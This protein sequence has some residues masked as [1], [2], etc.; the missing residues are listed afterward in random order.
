M[1]AESSA[2]KAVGVKP[3]DPPPDPN[4][5]DNFDVIVENVLRFLGV[6]S[7]VAF[8]ATSKS[9]RI[10]MTGEVEYRK[11]VISDTEIE[12]ARLMSAQ[13]QSSTLSSYIHKKLQ[14]YFDVFPF[15][16]DTEDQTEPY[17]LWDCGLSEEMFNKIKELYSHVMEE[18]VEGGQV[19]LNYLRC[20]D[21]LAAKKLVYDG[22]RLIDDEIGVFYTTKLTIQFAEGLFCDHFYFDVQEEDKPFEDY[23]VYGDNDDNNEEDS[24]L[25]HFGDDAPGDRIHLFHEERQ[26]FFSIMSD[27]TP[28]SLF[29]LPKCFFEFSEIV[30]SVMSIPIECIKTA[31]RPAGRLGVNLSLLGQGELEPGQLKHVLI[32]I[33]RE[34]ENIDAFRVVA[35]EMFYFQQGKILFYG[36]G[37]TPHLAKVIRF[38]GSAVFLDDSGEANYSF[39]ITL[40]FHCL[41]SIRTHKTTMMKMTSAFTR[42]ICQKI[43]VHNKIRMKSTMMTTGATTTTTTTIKMMT[44]TIVRPNF[45]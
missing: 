27:G 11:K 4:P 39:F 13:R 2:K 7:L 44:T 1:L 20:G 38:T 19:R 42:A 14:V 8:G 35:R 24:K 37:I 26:K 45:L 17:E 21:F 40:S 33:S 23:I 25:L 36:K 12:V 10:A 3:I 18:C 34:V 31:I 15:Y 6:R 32:D 29:I 30:G 43:W 28:G 16:N 5:F 41:T 22:M 9:H